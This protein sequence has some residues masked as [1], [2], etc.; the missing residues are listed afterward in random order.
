MG[1]DKNYWYSTSAEP[2]MSSN[3]SFNEDANTGD[4]F[5]ILL[6]SVDVLS[7]SHYGAG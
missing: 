1:K 4:R 2:A 3:W 6:A 5:A 7:A